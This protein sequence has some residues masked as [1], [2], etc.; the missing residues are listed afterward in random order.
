MKFT[1]M[2]ALM[3][4]MAGAGIGLVWYAT[5]A[6]PDSALADSASEEAEET[7]ASG[8]RKK[9][10]PSELKVKEGRRRSMQERLAGDAKAAGKKPAVAPPHYAELEKKRA[11]LEKQGIRLLDF[12]DP[13]APLSAEERETARAM[14]AAYDSGNAKAAIGFAARL[15]TSPSAEARAKAVEILGWSGKDALPQLAAAVSDEDPE[16]ARSAASHLES[17]ILE[18]EDGHEIAQ[19]VVSA[20]G[21]LD[22]PEAIE[23]LSHQL[24]GLE[25]EIAADAIVSLSGM[26]G[27][28][29]EAAKEAFKF[30]SGEE[31]Q[32]AGAVKDWAQRKRAELDAELTP[33]EYATARAMQAERAT[34]RARASM[35]NGG[36]DASGSAP[37]DAGSAAQPAA[38][39]P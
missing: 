13:F 32:G 15:L 1:A 38:P 11:E 8:S 16:I 20:I 39:Q 9:R 29:A 3:V 2:I 4:L 6:K 27:Q 37:A 34:A 31:W 5:R 25:P 23:S 18:Y 14:I 24:H 35:I 33:E 21:S 30:M 22:D 19:A 36:G 7:Q 28:A 10:K 26:G 12:E 17:L